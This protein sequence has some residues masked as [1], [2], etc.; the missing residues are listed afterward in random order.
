MAE[1]DLMSM[2]TPDPQTAGLGKW[3]IIHTYSGYENKVAQTILKKTENLQMSDRIF[4]VRIPTETVCEISGVSEGKPKE[5]TYERKIF[6]GYVLVRILYS[7]EVA[8]LIRSIRG[9]TGFLGSDPNNPIPLTDQEVAD[10]GVDLGTK[11]EIDL[12]IGD[13][14]V[15]IATHN[16]DM[17]GTIQSIDAETKRCTVLTRMMGRDVPIELDL[18]QVMRLT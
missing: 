17:E 2:Q 9:V 4:E 6:P 13:R 18:S 1:I 10:M 7:D 12:E 8:Y 5:K 11:V 16:K 15:I 3:Y 14:V